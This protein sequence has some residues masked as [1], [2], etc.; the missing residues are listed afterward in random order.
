MPLLQ[1]V[2]AVA[3]VLRERGH[4]P[5]E[6]QLMEDGLLMADICLPATRTVLLLEPPTAFFL[7]QR[8]QPV[9]QTILTWRLFTKRNW[10]VGPNHSKIG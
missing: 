8:R 2:T 9:G 10:Q 6:R 5:V 4:A 1:A 7:N 3:K